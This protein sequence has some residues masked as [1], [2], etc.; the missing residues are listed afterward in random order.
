MSK[1]NNSTNRTSDKTKRL[2]GDGND[3]DVL[4]KNQIRDTK[5]I[6]KS[7]IKRVIVTGVTGQDGSFMADFLLKNTDCMVYGAVRRL[8]VK[9]YTNIH[10]LKREPRFKLIN[11]DLTDDYS[12]R[13]AIVEIKPH[14]FLNFA[15]S[16]RL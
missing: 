1:E 12:I 15:E 10:H 16:N 9:N 14:Y 13:D 8:S 6:H 11:L 5:S 3:I 7:S 2:V 4:N